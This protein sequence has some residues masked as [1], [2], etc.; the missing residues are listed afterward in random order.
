MLPSDSLSGVTLCSR[1]Q[2]DHKWTQ[3]Q[4]LSN[5]AL[6]ELYLTF[7]SVPGTCLCFSRAPQA[8]WGA[9]SLLGVTSLS[10]LWLAEWIVGSTNIACLEP[11]KWPCG[12]S[13][14]QLRSAALHPGPTV[15]SDK[16]RLPSTWQQEYSGSKEA[17]FLVRKRQGQ[18]WHSTKQMNWAWKSKV[19]QDQATKVSHQR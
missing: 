3:L 12:N 16:G 5:P 14:S 4:R 11:G 15:T 17:F 13:R 7:S 6:A 19:G 10:D 8:I 18:R 1:R 2:R 9:V